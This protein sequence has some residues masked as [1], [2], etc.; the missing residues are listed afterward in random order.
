MDK[1]LRSETRA[2]KRF[3]VE[4]LV[5]T[6]FGSQSLIR[7]NTT[8]ISTTGMRLGAS[9]RLPDSQKKIECRIFFDDRIIILEAEIIWRRDTVMGVRFLNLTQEL[10]LTIAISLGKRVPHHVAPAEAPPQ[11]KPLYSRAA[12]P[13]APAPAARLT[14]NK[15]LLPE[16]PDLSEKWLSRT[17]RGGDPHD[18]WIDRRP[19]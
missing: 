13:K 15:P 18:K 19:F 16:R 4:Y 1:E 3:K 10:R 8:D 2:Q 12:V 14:Q 9:R 11:P 5:E 7:T 17:Q 6:G